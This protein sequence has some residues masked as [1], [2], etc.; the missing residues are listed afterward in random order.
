MYP[1]DTKTKEGTLFWS[2][3]K[4]PPSAIAFDKADILHCTFIASLACLRAT[5][6]YIPIPTKT[7]RTDEFRKHCGEIASQLK[8]AEF[9]PNED[10]AKEI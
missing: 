5:V 2:L 7:P 3:P 6:F 1:L 4:R 8:V 10:K 9:K